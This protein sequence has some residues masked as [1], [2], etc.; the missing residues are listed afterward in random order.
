M[1]FNPGMLKL[2]LFCKGMDVE[3]VQ[4]RLEEE[5]TGIYRIRAGLGSGLEIILPDNLYTNVPVTE[6]WV[7]GTPL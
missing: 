4:Q 7:K 6:P 2:E 3:P 5:G 1:D